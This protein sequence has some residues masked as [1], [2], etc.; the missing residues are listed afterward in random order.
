MCGLKRSTYDDYGL[1]P[2][3]P[4]FDDHCGK[5]HDP[6]MYVAYMAHLNRRRRLK[7]TGAE[8]F[9]KRAIANHS[10]WTPSK[11]SFVLEA[12]EKAAG[13]QQQH[14]NATAPQ[15]EGLGVGGAGGACG[16]R[17]GVAAGG[18]GSRGSGKNGIDPTRRESQGAL[19]GASASL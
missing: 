1:A 14:N 12:Q 5:E 17:N 2:G 15:G 18:G 10:F 8:E 13:N 19:A 9:A 11:T 16:G 3:S 6:W 7:C 4:S